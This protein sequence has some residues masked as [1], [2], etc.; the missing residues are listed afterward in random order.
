MSIDAGVVVTP[1]ILFGS[2]SQMRG[3]FLCSLV[4]N[5]VGQA[6]MGVNQLST[7]SGRLEH[8]D[9]EICHI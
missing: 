2:T 7:L 6:L 5:V 8:K 9:A 1:S 3:V 4:T